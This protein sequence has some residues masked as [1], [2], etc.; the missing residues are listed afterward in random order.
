M[1]PTEIC[2]KL[3][4]FAIT[5]INC[6]VCLCASVSLKIIR[7]IN[8]SP[9]PAGKIWDRRRNESNW[10]SHRP[11]SEK[12][13]HLWRVPHPQELPR[14]DSSECSFEIE[15][16]RPSTMRREWQKKKKKNPAQGSQVGS[17]E[18]KAFSKYRLIHGAASRSL[19]TQFR[20]GHVNAVFFFFL[21]SMSGIKVE[22][23]FLV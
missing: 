23:T 8:L 1:L 13:A 22:E 20:K 6:G 15:E 9:A 5:H 17:K 14:R 21:L 19:H 11:Q 2:P 10:G 16:F 18:Y 7:I 4:G 12:A 3:S